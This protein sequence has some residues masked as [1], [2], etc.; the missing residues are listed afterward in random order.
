MI[1]YYAYYSV[2]GYKDMY[3][4]NSDMKEKATF[5]LPLLPVMSKKAVSDP[6]LIKTIESLENLPKINILSSDNLRN[7]PKEALTMISH[8]GYK[9]M[10]HCSTSG[11][12]I[13]AF[14]DIPSNEKDEN[15]RS[16][17]FMMLF[18]GKKEDRLDFLAS[19]FFTHISTVQQ[20][21]SSM[22]AYDVQKNG[23]EF[24][25]KKMNEF[26][27]ETLNKPK[28]LIL[29]S[30]RIVPLTLKP[31]NVYLLVS[32]QQPIR[33]VI[34]EHKLQKDNVEVIRL[35]DIVSLDDKEKLAISLEK[36]IIKKSRYKEKSICWN[37]L[38]TLALLGV[39]LGYILSRK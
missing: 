25:L 32:K 2:G 19:Y 31:R 34:E 3:L 10:L 33:M 23:I 11:E 27:D 16:I 26:V 7:L 30:D 6:S 39:L 20:R 36:I 13:L 28:S 15:G 18:V 29:T 4:G 24:K 38:S 22:F 9:V 17:P 1:R 8:G 35:E 14:R 21:L 5:Y 37:T 12:D